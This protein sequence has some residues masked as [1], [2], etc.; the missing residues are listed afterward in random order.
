MIQMSLHYTDNPLN[1]LSVLQQYFTILSYGPP[2][3]ISNYRTW[4]SFAFGLSK[5]TRFYACWCESRNTARI[6]SLE[7]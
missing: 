4:K 5:K 7:W 3:C 1:V 2:S 6:S